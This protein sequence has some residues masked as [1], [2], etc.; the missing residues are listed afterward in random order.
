MCPL[1]LNKV[2]MNKELRKVARK[3]IFLC[4]VGDK[5]MAKEISYTRQMRTGIQQLRNTV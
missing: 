3:E 1:Y 4:F 2:K 5:Q